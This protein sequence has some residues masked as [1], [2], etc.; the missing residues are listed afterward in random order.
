M[1][2]GRSFSPSEILQGNRGR[3]AVI[4]RAELPLPGLPAPG[5]WCLT[6]QGPRQASQSWQLVRQ[7]KNTSQHRLRGRVLVSVVREKLCGMK[8]WRMLQWFY[9]G[10][11]LYPLSRPWTCNSRWQFLFKLILVAGQGLIAH[12]SEIHWA[13]GEK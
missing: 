3:K 11:K 13:T 6:L 1:H 2:W 9:C 8:T 5:P 12:D 10:C 7:V 4:V